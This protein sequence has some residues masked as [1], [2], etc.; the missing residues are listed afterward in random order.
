MISP[1]R[2]Y[3]GASLGWNTP[4]PGLML[5][6]IWTRLASLQT[7]SQHPTSPL[8]THEKD[9]E[10]LKLH[11]GLATVT[12]YGHF[13]SWE[14]WPQAWRW[15]SF[16]LLHTRLWTIPVQ[17][18]GHRL[19]KPAESHPLQKLEIILRSEVWVEHGFLSRVAWQFGRISLK[20]TWS[21]LGQ[22][23][24][25]TTPTSMGWGPVPP[26][27]CLQGGATVNLGIWPLT[28]CPLYGCLA[29]HHGPVCLLESIKAPNN[30]HTPPPRLG[31]FTFLFLIN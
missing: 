28:F 12:Q 11:L 5:S 25:K 26:H 1:A 23:P 16:S 27:A 24:D 3:P 20:Q 17:A 7:R 8:L 30:T 15:N 6:S 4:H 31:E 22:K 10:I 21:S 13:T 29:S 14:S 9:Q 18:G 19:M 2:V